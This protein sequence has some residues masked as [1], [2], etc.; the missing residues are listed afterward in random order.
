M[1]T[2]CHRIDTRGFA[3]CIGATSASP[4]PIGIVGRVYGHCPADRVPSRALPAPGAGSYRAPMA[5]HRVLSRWVATACPICAIEP[6]APLV[7]S[8]CKQDFFAD[9]V[10]RCERCAIRLPSGAGVCGPCLRQPP[11]F[12]ATFA[13]ADYA[14]PIDGL[15]LALKFGHRLELAPVLGELLAERVPLVTC[16]RSLVVP[17]PLSFERLAERGFNQSHEIARATARVLGLTFDGTALMRV[18]HAPAQV[19][20][21]R[22]ERRRNIRSAFAV[23]RALHGLRLV[24]VDDVMTTGSTLDEIAHVLKAAGAQH[25]T[26][27]VVARTP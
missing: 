2:V 19:S 16:P 11:H 14:T 20:L 13:L 9:R 26:N 6:G 24:V 5:L 10:H 4:G 17:V 1:R 3:V 22:E 23:R 12:D 7:C 8:G 18:R 25:I 15:L 21:P 27:L